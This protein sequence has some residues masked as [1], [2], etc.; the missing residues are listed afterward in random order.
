MR[1]K[2]QLTRSRM[3][4]VPEPLQS[5]LFDTPL[6][7]THHTFSTHV[8]EQLAGIDKAFGTQTAS[9]AIDHH[10][11]AARQTRKVIRFEG[12][13]SEGKR[14]VTSSASSM[15]SKCGKIVAWRARVCRWCK[16]ASISRG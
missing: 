2:K 16:R 7:D 4:Q 6:R 11:A 8:L 15:C 9:P 3:R 13:D 14:I 10:S 12:E 5:P 1:A